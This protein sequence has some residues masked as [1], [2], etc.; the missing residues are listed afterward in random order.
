MNNR[1]VH[2]QG[3]LRHYFSIT[4]RAAGLKVDGDVLVEI[5]DI[6]Q[7]IIEAAIE[8]TLAKLKEETSEPV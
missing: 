1:I 7:L 3:L 6:V 2:A 5:D 8:E 4:M